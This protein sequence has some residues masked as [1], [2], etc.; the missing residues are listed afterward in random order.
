MA[1]ILYDEL[2]IA[3]PGADTAIISGGVS[4][5]QDCHLVIQITPSASSIVDVTM[6]ASASA[7][8]TVHAMSAASALTAG[9]SYRWRITGK[10]D[11]SYNVRVRTDTVI[12]HLSITEEPFE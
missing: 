5:A 3:A 9:A 8:V 11:R 12:R 2:S 4:P 1:R 6:A 7:A 10:K